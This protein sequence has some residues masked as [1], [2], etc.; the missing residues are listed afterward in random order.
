VLWSH[1][2]KWCVYSNDDLQFSNIRLGGHVKPIVY[3]A[4]PRQAAIYGDKVANEIAEFQLSHVL[5]VKDL[6][7]KE[8]IDCEFQLTRACDAFITQEYADKVTES[9]MGIKARG[10]TCVREVQYTGPKDAE[11]VR[12]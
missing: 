7:E 6:V 8:N 4:F 10:N 9:F 3:F 1:C 2:A 12:D 11:M 5:A